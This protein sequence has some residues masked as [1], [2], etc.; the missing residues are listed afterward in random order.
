MPILGTTAGLI[1]P[2]LNGGYT[3]TYYT[4]EQLLTLIIEDVTYWM[5]DSETP[6]TPTYP[7][8]LPYAGQT[9]QPFWLE[10]KCVLELGLLLEFLGEPSVPNFITNYNGM[11]SVQ[12][13][14]GMSDYYNGI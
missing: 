5:N 7:E 12:V 4:Q 2:I 6:Y 3:M 11:L 14:A 13:Y 9:L 8:I 1:T 10:E